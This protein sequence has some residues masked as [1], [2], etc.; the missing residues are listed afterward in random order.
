MGNIDIDIR[1]SVKYGI[2]KKADIAHPY[3]LDQTGSRYK[4]LYTSFSHLKIRK[5]AR[6]LTH[7]GI[8]ERQF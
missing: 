5:A 4:L 2:E 8:L 7:L 1:K 3:V 6:D